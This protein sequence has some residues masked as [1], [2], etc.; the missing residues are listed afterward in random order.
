MDEYE[1]M[2]EW[3][4]MYGA[5]IE[6][7]NVL[8]AMENEVTKSST[9]PESV[10]AV[11]A[12]KTVE[13]STSAVKSVKN[14]AISRPLDENYVLKRPPMDVKSIACVLSS[15]ERV[16]L[17]TKQKE[18]KEEETNKE[19]WKLGVPIKEMLENIEKRKVQAVVDE[20]NETMDMDV[21]PDRVHQ[22]ELWLNK[23][24]PK[25]FID[26][27]SD[28]RTNRDV[29]GWL[30]SWDAC[31]FKSKAKAPLKPAFRFGND[32]AAATESKPP[33]D[34]RPEHKII[35]ICGPPGAGKTTLAGIAARHA[36]YNPIEVNASDD[37][38]SSVLREKIISAMEMQSIFGNSRP[39][40][41]ILD[42]IDGALHGNEGR[43]AIGAL[44]EL[45]ATPYSTKKDKSKKAKHP[46]IRPIICICND[47]YA[48]VLR[49]LRKLAK[50][51]VLSTPDQRQLM[52]RLKFICKNESL[53]APTSLL[54]AL[55]QR[56]DN[57]IRFC[58]N[59]LQFA[60]ARTK[61][62]TSSMIEDMMGQKDLSKGA[63]DVWDVIFYEPRQ[64]KKD[65]TISS[66][67]R[68]FEAADR[69]A[70]HELVLNGLHDNLLP[71]AFNDPTLVKVHQALECMEFADL[72]DTQIRTHQQYALMSYYS[73]AAVAVSYACCTGSR[74]RIEYPKSNYDHRRNL[75]KSQSILEALIDSNKSFRVG[76]RVLMVDVLPW[77][78]RILN[79]NI[80]TGHSRDEKQHLD[81][82]IELLTSLHVSYR[83]LHL[84]GGV[85][86]YVL[87][88]AINEL[89]LYKHLENPR[90][91]LPIA[92]RQLIA[93]EVELETLRRAD[94]TP[95]AAIPGDIEEVKT[96]SIPTVAP[97]SPVTRHP[98]GYIKRK[99]QDDV[100]TTKKRFAVRFK[101][102]EGYTSGI[103]R[104]NVHNGSEQFQFVS[105][106]RD[107]LLS[108]LTIYSAGNQDTSID[109]ARKGSKSFS[110]KNENP[111]DETP[112]NSSPK[113]SLAI[114]IHRLSLNRPYGVVIT[115]KPSPMKLKEVAPEITPTKVNKH[116]I[117]LLE[118]K[119]RK[120]SLVDPALKVEERLQQ[121][122]QIYAQKQA[123]KQDDVQYTF[124]PKISYHSSKLNRQGS[125]HERLYN[126]AKQSKPSPVSLLETTSINIKPTKSSV[127]DRLHRKA[128]EYKAKQEA[129]RRAESLE[130][131][132]LRNR[133]K[134]S[135]KSLQLLQRQKSN[136]PK[137]VEPLKSEIPKRINITQAHNIYARQLEWKEQKDARTARERWYQEKEE[138]QA[139]TFQNPYLSNDGLSA[140]SS[141]SFYTKA[142]KWAKEKEANRRRK[143]QIAEFERMKSCPFKLV[144]AKKP[145]NKDK[146]LEEI[147]AAFYKENYQDSI[148]PYPWQQHATENGDVY[149]YNPLTQMTQWEIPMNTK[150]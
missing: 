78:M 110:I 145:S 23:Y 53:E 61:Q 135:D 59:S 7:A 29:L 126:Q 18:I 35:L 143:E 70:S 147:V 48:P 142:I 97:D 15:G 43:S 65:D 72:V 150:R 76:P 41:I 137:T 132:Q 11:K 116:S 39:N 33:E 34:I 79:P 57:D 90:P 81:R 130:A 149:Y 21:E 69:F 66:F 104:P 20:E 38:T 37:R 30:K 83:P 99:R 138:K 25:H 14:V 44:Q 117:T 64:K 77:L 63:Y 80:Q 84:P 71:L 91:L 85:T 6:A 1:E 146:A 60:S 129:I 140:P 4:A 144:K 125:V 94:H 9:L 17:R 49:P 141:D 87:E 127:G 114:P 24:R 106:G 73:V 118:N 28:E 42:E 47:Q 108:S 123:A 32:K 45:I 75:E 103:K 10:S 88:P 133:R 12:V 62:L 36:G 54:S 22:D 26:L 120:P 46:L 19:S 13:K 2:D 136:Q 5:D 124:Q 109:H 40:C 102:N 101:F 82:L 93:R 121:L 58:L 68:A 119:Q 16:F 86:D 128:Q 27:L 74:R 107:R 100:K 52:S 112:E 122:G 115:S 98:F 3:E 113:Q 96:Q 139:C 89:V 111:E 31:V 134:I 8:A 50:I 55:C 67:T 131:T 56:A 51:F 105:M 92:T 148:I 95:S